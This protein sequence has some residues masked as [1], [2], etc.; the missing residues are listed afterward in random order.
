[1]CREDDL[2]AVS[3]TVFDGRTR[4]RR[5][6]HHRLELAPIA[7]DLVESLAFF[8]LVAIFLDILPPSGGGKGVVAA[9]FEDLRR[10]SS[11]PADH[12]PFGRRRRSGDRCG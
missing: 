9:V 10:V 12:S 7:D 3:E 8:F 11:G 5:L 2:L 4:L 6:G 1:M